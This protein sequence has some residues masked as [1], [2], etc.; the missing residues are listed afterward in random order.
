MQIY[1]LFPVIL[2]LVRRTAGHHALL[3]AASAAVQLAWLSYLMYGPPR[4]GGSGTLRTT[5]TRCCPAISSTSWSVRSPPSTWTETLEFVR[6]TPPPDHGRR[7]GHR[8]GN[9]DLLP[10]RR[11]IAE[12]LPVDAAAVLQPVMVPWSLAAVALPVRRWARCGTERRR[13][14]SRLDRGL[15]IASDR[16]FGVF[17]VHPLVLWAAAAGPVPLVACPV[18]AG[19]H[20]RLPTCSSS[21]DRLAFAEAVPPH[22]F[23]LALTG[24][25]RIAPRSQHRPPDR[26]EKNRH[27][28]DDADPARAPVE[29][30]HQGHH[31]GDRRRPADAL[32]H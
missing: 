10:G 6:R 23:S 2:W 14:G 13:A 21:P 5:P 20:G 26:R 1:L 4:P 17:L 11:R 24:R 7:G 3:L 27:V 30:P 19:P 15:D 28:R 16:S 29:A 25:R 18:R 31:D 22:P 9:R 32:L 12:M 8:R